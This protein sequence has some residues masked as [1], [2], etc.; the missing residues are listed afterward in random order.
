[1]KQADGQLLA[2]LNADEFFIRYFSAQGFAV[3]N[4]MKTAFEVMRIGISL[5]LLL[6]AF[7][8]YPD[9]LQRQEHFYEGG[10]QW[11]IRT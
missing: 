9:T 7:G 1:V 3:D 10:Y 11:H 2:L 6:F 5:Y 8:S 4:F